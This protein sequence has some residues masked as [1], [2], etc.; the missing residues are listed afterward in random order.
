MYA[1]EPPAAAHKRM[2]LKASNPDLPTLQK[3]YGQHAESV[4]EPPKGIENSFIWLNTN[5]RLI[6][7]AP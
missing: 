4:I 3:P 1:P 5:A 7:I 6:E 2:P